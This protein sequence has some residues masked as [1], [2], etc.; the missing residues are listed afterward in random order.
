[1]IIRINQPTNR[2]NMAILF[3]LLLL[4]TAWGAAATL[5]SAKESR[6]D[7]ETFLPVILSSSAC[8]SNTGQV[9]SQGFALQYELDNPVRPAWNHPDKN[10]ELRSYTPNNDPTLV[11]ELIDYGSDDPTQPPQFATLF[12]PYKVPALTGFYRI[13]DWIWAPSPNPGTQGPPAPWPPVTVMGLATTPG[14]LIHVPLSG[15]DIGGGMEVI[16]LFADADSVTLRYT[17]E[18]SAGSPGYAVHI[19]NICT[20]VNLLALYNALDAPN[21]PR[22]V[23]VAP[24]DRPYSYDLPQLPAGQPVGTARGAEVRIAIVDTGT[25][26][27]PRSCNE[28]WQI[29]P[30]YTG[31][32]PP[33]LTMTGQLEMGTDHR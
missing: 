6:G 28:W 32:C 5:S 8:T 22:Y 18:D 16:V 30:G 29:R 24:P 10:I 9:Y 27:D 19:D 1:M 7:D 11:R 31:T 2:R 23:Y 4:G 3:W 12:N 13:H 26:M 33:A 15:Y 25:F 14:E 21:G 20:D 17:R